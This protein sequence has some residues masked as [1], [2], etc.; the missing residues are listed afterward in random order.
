[1]CV[2][3]LSMVF[4]WLSIE[5]YD[6]S[7]SEI[8]NFLWKMAWYSYFKT[9]N[10]NRRFLIILNYITR[11]KKNTLSI[12]S[13]ILHIIITIMCR[14]LYYFIEIIGVYWNFCEDRN[15]TCKRRERKRKRKNITSNIEGKSYTVVL[16]KLHIFVTTVIS[17]RGKLFHQFQ[18][19]EVTRST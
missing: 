19:K 13:Y 12:P 18:W 3:I 10:T 9:G 6:V 14:P 15:L 2:Y 11:Y 17:P 4:L 7:Y 8:S 1:M 5:V 16:T